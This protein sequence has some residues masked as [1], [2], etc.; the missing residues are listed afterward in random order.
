MGHVRKASGDELGSLPKIAK[1]EEVAR[2]AVHLAS[3]HSQLRRSL[4]S[5]R[6]SLPLAVSA[7]EVASLETIID[8]VSIGSCGAR[9]R[10]A[11]ELRGQC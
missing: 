9:C 5:Q 6:R 11:E 8:E 1:V 3:W 2:R 7:Q 4:R 10:A